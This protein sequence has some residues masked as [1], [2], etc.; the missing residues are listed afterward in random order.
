[1]LNEGL[2]KK[3]EKKQRQY[4]TVSKG[5]APYTGLATRKADIYKTL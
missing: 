2:T 3:I 4:T 1:M 5:F